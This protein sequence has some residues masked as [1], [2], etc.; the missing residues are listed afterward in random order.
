MNDA[1]IWACIIGGI[2]LTW[3]AINVAARL[4]A[5]RSIFKDTLEQSVEAAKNGVKVTF[6][7]A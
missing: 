7:D 4:K 6:P 2:C 5:A 1:Q 3:H